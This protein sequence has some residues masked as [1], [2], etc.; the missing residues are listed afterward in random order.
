M[1]SSHSLDRLDT[2]F[3]DDRLVADA[4]LLLPATLAQHAQRLRIRQP[5]SGRPRWCRGLRDGI[6]GGDGR[7]HDACLVE[8]RR[9]NDFG[10]GPEAR[11]ELLVILAD[12]TTDDDRVWRDEAL[13]ASQIRVDPLRPPLPSQLLAGLDAG[14]GQP[15]SILPATMMW[16]S[17]VLGRACHPGTGRFR[18][19][20]RRGPSR[21]LREAH[22]TRRTSP[23]PVP[24]HRHRS[25]RRSGDQVDAQGA[26]LDSSR[27]S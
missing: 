4:G 21:R 20:F 3:D 13:E 12:S 5:G 10:G 7:A 23:R 15:L 9:G 16:P 14:R 22:G 27:S 24:P 1:R 2:A 18:C 19:P 6:S 26:R 8:E 17:S 11:D 25:G